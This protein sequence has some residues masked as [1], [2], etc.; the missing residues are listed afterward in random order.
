[1]LPKID[2][3]GIFLQRLSAAPA[4]ASFEEART[5]LTRTLNE[6]EDELSGVPFDHDRWRS[7]GRMYPPEDDSIRSVPDH[8][9]VKRFRSRAHNTFISDNG[10]IEIR[11][12]DDVIVLQ[13]AGTDGR[14]VWEP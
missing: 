1:M 9:S 14:G 6:V 3:F 8:R 10:A 5:L 7:D 13:K 2:R 11:T 4:A 12:I